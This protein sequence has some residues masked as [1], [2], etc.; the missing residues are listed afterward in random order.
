[1]IFQQPK[2]F[3]L[4]PNLQP[5]SIDEVPIFAIHEKAQSVDAVDA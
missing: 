4:Q 1:M 5:L 2:M 3:I